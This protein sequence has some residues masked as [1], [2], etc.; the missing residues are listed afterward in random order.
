MLPLQTQ[1]RASI[2]PHA[3]Q[4]KMIKMRFKKIFGQF[5]SNESGWIERSNWVRW[6]ILPCQLCLVM[7]VDDDALDWIYLETNSPT[8]NCMYYYC[9]YYYCS[10]CSQISP[11][12]VISLA[13]LIPIDGVCKK[14]SRGLLATEHWNEIQRTPSNTR[15][16]LTCIR[17]NKRRFWCSICFWRSSLCFRRVTSCFK[18]LI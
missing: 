4:R 18:H 5:A 10:Y 16:A 13:F 2:P 1:H 12:R 17:N 14:S 8:V 15:A 9:Y 11:D 7:V 6:C 3:N